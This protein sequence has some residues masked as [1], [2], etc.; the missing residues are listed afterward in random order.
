MDAKKKQDGA[1]RRDF[2]KLAGTSAPAAVAAMAVGTTDAAAEEVVQ[3][4]GLRKTEHVKK[5]L[6]SARF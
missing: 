4:S 3:G 6:A 1:S 5:Y 2:L